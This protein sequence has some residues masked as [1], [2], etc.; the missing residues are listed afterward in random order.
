MGRPGVPGGEALLQERNLL[1]L[2]LTTLSALPLMGPLNAVKLEKSNSV[3]THRN[4]IFD[5][6]AYQSFNNGTMTDYVPTDDD[7]AR[8]LKPSEGLN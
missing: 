7:I 2:S 4:W 8:G 3:R 5:M 6:S 1:R